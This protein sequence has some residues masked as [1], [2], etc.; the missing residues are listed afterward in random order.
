MPCVNCDCPFRQMQTEDNP[1]S[2]PEIRCLLSDAAQSVKFRKGEMLFLQGQSSSSLYSLSRGMVKIFC[3]NS[4]GQEQIVGLSNPG[5]LLVGLQSIN[6]KR[7]AYSAA[8]ATTVE[9][10][11]INHGILLA[12]LHE[13]PELALR[14]MEAMKAQLIHSRELIQVLGRKHAAAKIAAFILLMTPRSQHGTCRFILPFSRLEIASL[15]G[16]SEETVCRVMADMK[17]KEMIHA[18][19]GNIEIRDLDRIHAVAEGDAGREFAR[20]LSAV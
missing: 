19:R 16:L 13:Q 17:R 4:D 1:F 12:R 9:A 7:Y 2:A 6:E 10:C 5:S 15:L 11:K 3:H 18:P 8:A 14:I 20:K